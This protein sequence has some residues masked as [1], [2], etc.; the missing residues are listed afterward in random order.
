MRFPTTT[1]LGV[2]LAWA[3]VA[4]ADIITWNCDNDHDGAI[5]C[6]QTGWQYDGGTQTYK[7]NIQG[8]QFWGPGHMVMDFTT[9]TVGDPTITFINQV[10]N[11]TT[12]AWTGYLINLTLD[13]AT[14][15]TSYSV[16]NLAVTN[17]GNWTATI[18]QPLTYTGVNGSGQYEYVG[19]I[20]FE[21]GTPVGN[22]NELDFSYKVTFAGSTSYHAIQEMSPVPEP[23]MI[24]VLVSGLLGLFVARRRILGR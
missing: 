14:P 15:L 1:L 9:D 17:P 2:F 7:L 23:G 22:G 24:A 21:G 16:S 11:D 19:H 10:Q 6:V 12:F 8:D 18:T 4:Q 13:A 3:S 5:N 20:D